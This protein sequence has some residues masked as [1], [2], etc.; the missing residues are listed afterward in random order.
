MILDL[1]TVRNIGIAAHI[2]AGIEIADLT[3]F[4][5]YIVITAVIDSDS[6]LRAGNVMGI[7]VKGHAGTAERYA[8]T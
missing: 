3:V 6:L 7:T 5:L 8:G 4:N 2:D 1:S